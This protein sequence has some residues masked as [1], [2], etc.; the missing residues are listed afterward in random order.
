MELEYKEV[1]QLVEA[2]S[3]KEGRRPRMLVAKMG[4]V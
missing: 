4:Q 2:F 3:M 1:R